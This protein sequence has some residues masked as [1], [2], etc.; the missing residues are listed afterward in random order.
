MPSTIYVN[1][2]L[3]EPELRESIFAGDFH[4]IIGREESLEIVHW[5][6]TL[7]AETF[8][9][10]DPQLA[11]YSLPVEEFIRRVAPLKSRFTN[12]PRTREL[13]RSLLIT[14]GCDPQLTYFDL[15]R[16]RVVPA[17]GYLTT[18]V[19]YAYKAHRDTWYAHPPSLV[20]FWTPVFDATGRDVMSFWPGYFGQPVRNTGFDYDDWVKNHR[21]AA[22]NQVGE[23]NRPHPLP[24]QPIDAGREI[25][26]ALNAGDMTLFSPCH[27]HATADN[28]SGRTR[29]SFDLRMVNI[30]DLKAGRGPADVDGSARGTTLPDF[31]RVS[32]F[33]PLGPELL[34]QRYVPA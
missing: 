29:F 31:I 7:L 5:I 27:L 17:S 15:P 4:L 3:T 14:L 22:I 23:E 19:S 33:E 13:C 16:L 11:Q 20:N 32:D 24:T 8:D 21:Y 12:D 9:N 25:R 30:E 34:P 1:R 26:I 10:L 28:T 2:S 18:G 6:R